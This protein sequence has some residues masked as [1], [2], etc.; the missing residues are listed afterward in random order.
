M[1]TSHDPANSLSCVIID[2]EPANHK[3]LKSHIGQIPW[4]MLSGSCFDAVQ[5]MEIIENKNPDI[6]FLDINMPEI[7][8]LEL[9]DMRP[10]LGSSVII[11]SAFEKFAIQGYDYDVISF[12]PKPVTYKGFV[13]AIT[14]ATKRKGRLLTPAPV[15]PGKQTASGLQIS[16]DALGS[17]PAFDQQRLWI[18]SEKKLQCIFYKNISFIT[19]EQNYVRIYLNDRSVLRTRAT[20]SELAPNLPP[21]FI[22]TH[23]SY[24]VNRYQISS[25]E[26]NTIELYNQLRVT[27]TKDERNEIIQRLAFG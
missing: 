20:L 5:G 12:L 14:K 18:K 25:I 4:L 9:L 16:E 17:L 1:K 26:G 6:V 8:G 11:T 10:A 15:A 23:R 2:D 19:G 7:N 22:R 13:K 24:I 3:I 21:H 27:I